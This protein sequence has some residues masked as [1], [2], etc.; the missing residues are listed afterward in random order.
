M[1]VCVFVRACVEIRVR[2]C[3]CVCVGL[4]VCV[5]VRIFIFIICEFV[6]FLDGVL[7]CRW[8]SMSICSSSM[9]CVV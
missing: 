8:C 9:Y 6:K 5:Y 7:W 2:G 3:V 4:C 1:C